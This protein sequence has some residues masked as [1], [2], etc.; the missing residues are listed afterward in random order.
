MNEKRFVFPTG[1]PTK[2]VEDFLKGEPTK[3]DFC[4]AEAV[5]RMDI[6]DFVIP[7]AGVRS[8][9]GFH[10]CATCK[11]I[12]DRRDAPALLQRSEDRMRKLEGRLTEAGRRVIADVHAGFWKAFQEKLLR[13]AKQ[14]ARSPWLEAVEA[15]YGILKTL[16]QIHQA[17]VDPNLQASKGELTRK[18]DTLKNVR[19][20][21]DSLTTGVS[22]SAFSA[23][24]ERDVL[25]A[26]LIDRVKLKDATT[27]SFSGDAR[28][29]IWQASQSVPL[30]APLKAEQLPGVNGFWWFTPPLAVEENA[31]GQG[32]QAVLWGCGGQVPGKEDEAPYGLYLTFSV[33]SRIHLKGLGVRLAPT[34]LWR[35]PL[36]ESFE[37][38]LREAER[39]Y[40]EVKFK[41]TRE[42][43]TWDKKGLASTLRV[44]E[45]VSRFFLAA[46][47]W[48]E[49]EILEARPE[50]IER[51]ERRRYVRE[52][53]LS[54]QPDVR[55]I[56]LR[57]RKTEGSEETGSPE[58]CKE[59]QWTCRWVVDG[60][61]K[62]QRFGPGRQDKKTIYVQS[63]VK[64]PEG[65][66]L[67]P[68]A[69]KVFAVVR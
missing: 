2:V 52:H 51:H 45:A 17:I 43:E 59:V 11:E 61:W 58:P 16:D 4:N 46:N 41:V 14:V 39:S 15:Q 44:I 42:L 30:D 36:G 1:T 48:M 13:D 55:V 50:H 26:M 8:V 27:Y 69:K 31:F 19:E 68:K 10:A 20:L 18:L 60:H 28:T 37:E 34:I 24:Q 63:F 12:I 22:P 66:P 38:M 40:R 56:A 21:M 6:P 65:L 54:K 67:K 64:G 3:C 23:S 35:W 33:Y 29:A 5:V 7:R 9:D 49:Q 53:K 32:I 62:T 57:K 25:A 47:V